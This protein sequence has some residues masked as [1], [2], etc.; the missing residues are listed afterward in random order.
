MG[1]ALSQSHYVDQDWIKWAKTRHQTRATRQLE[2][3]WKNVTVRYE[4]H[5]PAKQHLQVMLTDSLEVSTNWTQYFIPCMCLIIMHTQIY[6]DHITH[7]SKGLN[8]F[9]LNVSKQ[10]LYIVMLASMNALFFKYLRFY[11][12]CILYSVFTL[13]QIWFLY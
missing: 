3:Q 10:F 1:L 13:P 6:L 5:G 7:C 12:F 2:N 4:T 9:F 8:D 11:I